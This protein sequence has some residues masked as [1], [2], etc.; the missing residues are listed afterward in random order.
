[1]IWR[2]NLAS[3]SAREGRSG[4]TIVAPSRRPP[5]L[6]GAPR[7]S[8]LL[9]VL[10]LGA[11]ATAGRPRDARPED[12]VLL[13]VQ[14]PAASGYAWLA[15]GG[16]LRGGDRY[17]LKVEVKQPL[18]VYV[19]R[20]VAGGAQLTLAPPA[21]A[22]AAAPLLVPEDGWLTLDGAPGAE[23][24]VVVAARR[25]LSPEQ[26]QAAQAR[27]QLVDERDPPQSSTGTRGDEQRPRIYLGALGRDGVAALRLPFQHA[28]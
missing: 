17:S 24:L 26:L 15:R 10:G 28:P 22:S 2:M 3:L 14:I 13:Q 20:R 6:R 19:S 5:V 27:A 25:A 9:L 7:W 21:E 23:D 1:M 4:P 8:P 12:A 18:Q 11:C 16:A